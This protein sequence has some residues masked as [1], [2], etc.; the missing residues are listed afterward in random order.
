MQ[1]V[2]NHNVHITPALLKRVCD[3]GYELPVFLVRS[4]QVELWNSNQIDSRAEQMAVALAEPD[5]CLGQPLIVNLYFQSGLAVLFEGNHRARAA[6]MVAW[7]WVP[8]VFA[9]HAGTGYRSK[10]VQQRLDDGSPY[11]RWANR[12]VVS[13][14]SE[15]DP[16]KRPFYLFDSYTLTR[17]ILAWVGVETLD[18][19]A[20]HHPSVY[21]QC[22]PTIHEPQATPEGFQQ[23]RLENQQ[24]KFD[25]E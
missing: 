3:C 22:V 2:T 1:P 7:P 25:Q 16:T 14:L 17:E 12:I 5:S 6:C 24:S 9:L 23:A 21:T 18:P 8:V 13:K 15:F 11:M 19:H 10:Y 4:D 20:E